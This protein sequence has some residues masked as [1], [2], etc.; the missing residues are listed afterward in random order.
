[1]ISYVIPCHNEALVLRQTYLA[2]TRI[3]ESLGQSFEVWMVDDGSTDQTWQI[4]DEIHAADKRWKALRFSRNFGHQAAIRAGLQQ[5]RGA[6]VI[7]LDAD[8]QDP[9]C[10]TRE[11][12]AK[13][14]EGYAVVYGV[15]RQR[16][17]HL[18][19]R[20]AY[21]VFYRVLAEQATVSI[22]RDAG[23][24]CLMDRRVVDT[25]LSLP[26]RTQFLRGLRAWVGGRQIGVE[27]ER[28]ARAAG[29]PSYTF[30]KLR[31]LGIDGLCSF[32][33]VPLQLVT[34]LGFVVS[35]VAFLGAVFTLLQRMYA[36]WFAQIGL[37][38]VPGFATTVIGM[39]F[40]G[41]VQ[42]LSLGIVGEYVG[43]IYDEVKQ[44]PRWV[45]DAILDG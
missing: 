17:E 41:G 40:L 35:L 45:L 20:I 32:S 10:L 33:T 8:L 21:D 15:R 3:G 18:L 26:E 13:W 9:P 4:M 6:A 2:V 44:R 30:R 39:L 22:P 38:P 24:F 19:K 43:R 29:A 14:K 27:Y 11:F 5:A 42:L 1:M 28:Q 31:Q 12:I 37:R 16:K 7:V 23:D 25:L 36:D 34:M